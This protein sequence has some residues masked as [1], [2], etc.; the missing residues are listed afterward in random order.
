[1]LHIKL[2]KCQVIELEGKN[3]TISKVLN[4]AIEFCQDNHCEAILTFHGFTFDIDKN[5][6]I[7]EK[8]KEY[9]MWEQK[10]G[11]ISKT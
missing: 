10:N 9:R 7:I 5:S 2:K 8:V 3:T 11:N 4:E 1:M 6:D